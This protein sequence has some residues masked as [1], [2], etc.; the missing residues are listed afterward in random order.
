MVDAGKGSKYC[1][2]LCGS[3]DKEERVFL[4]WVYR[5]QLLDIH[6]IYHNFAIGLRYSDQWQPNNISELSNSPH[7]HNDHQRRS[8]IGWQM[9]PQHGKEFPTKAK[10][11]SAKGLARMA[12]RNS[13]L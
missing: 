8:T 11:Q 2:G 7:S 9:F 12:R 13:F 6:L 1:C 10:I 3:C 5:N 4:C